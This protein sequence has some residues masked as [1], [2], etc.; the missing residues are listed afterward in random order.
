MASAEA[1][2]EPSAPASARPGT[3]PR[4]GPRS[5][6]GLGTRKSP[7]AIAQTE[8]AKALF[9]SAT[10]GGP[11]TIS[12]SASGP[13][14][15]IRSQTTEGDRNQVTALHQMDAKALWTTDLEADLLSGDTDIVVHSLKDMPTQLPAGC[16][17]GG[18]I[19][20]TERRDCLVMS[21]S[22]AAKGWKTLADLPEG[23]VVGTSSVRR[24]A[25][26]R[27]Q[28]PRLKT[29]DVR[30]NVGT[31]LRKLDDE[32]GPFAAL[33]LAAAGL[34]RVGLGDRISCFL[35]RREGAWLGAVGQGAI[36]LEIRHQDLSAKQL[37]D[38]AMLLDKH[39]QQTLWECLAERSLLRTLE[40]GCSVP[41]AVE[42][43][44][45][46]AAGDA[47][48]TSSTSATDSG[49]VDADTA[50]LVL[51]ALVAS[52][53]GKRVI[54]RNLTATVRSREQAE[55]AGLELARRLVEGG[56]EEILREITLNRKIIVEGG[57]A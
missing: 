40:G 44:W 2:Q 41:V 6:Y 28:H 10:R 23:S 42:S 8:I 15:P 35:S 57:N 3:G 54:E 12:A 4:T 13:E 7:L 50:Q 11:A 19:A 43:E 24:L 53:D 32:S 26:L 9:I 18:A 25:Q 20:R 38:S 48:H 37:C 30:G 49:D 33:I 51:F 5:S 36:G 1:A 22:S 16:S 52:V 21:P 55:D 31:R 56:A 17:L 45:R 29:R 27:A 14:F 34:Q 46:P 39:G 47:N